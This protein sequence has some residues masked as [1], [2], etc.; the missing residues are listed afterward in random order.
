MIRERDVYKIGKIGR[1]HGVNGEMIF[2]FTDDVF[3]RADTDCILL[4]I[5]GIMVP[6]FIDEYRFCSDETA[7]LRLD[8]VDTPERARELAG[9]EVFFLRALADDAYEAESPSAVVGYTVVNAADGTTVG[10]IKSVDMT[11]S[12]ALFEIDAPD[13]RRL[14]VPAAEEYVKGI[15]DAEKRIMVELPEGLLDLF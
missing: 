7:L 8:G 2:T 9:S 14:L 11:T 13:G 5:D 1:P 3:D 10:D 4:R 12:N 15:D 6:F